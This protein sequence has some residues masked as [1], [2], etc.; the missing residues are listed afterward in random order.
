MTKFELTKEEL[1]KMGIPKERLDKAWAEYD[2]HAHMI[3]TYNTVKT[4]RKSFLGG[5]VLGVFVGY[6]LGTLVALALYGNWVLNL[7]D[8]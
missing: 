2:K 1:E 6:V 4:R 8:K 7:L 5:I 3:E